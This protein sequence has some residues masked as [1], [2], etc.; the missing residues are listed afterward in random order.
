MTIILCPLFRFKWCLAA[1]NER[2]RRMAQKKDGTD[3]ADSTQEG[4]AS[5]QIHLMKFEE[6]LDY[7][8]LMTKQPAAIA[9]ALT[10]NGTE[11]GPG[12]VG[13]AGFGSTVKIVLIW[14]TQSAHFSRRRL[15]GALMI[16]RSEHSPVRTLVAPSETLNTSEYIPSYSGWARFI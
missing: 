14:D 12:W 5:L 2:L 3:D 13:W 6:S 8:T 15:Q 4:D 9:I 7:H 1:K 11:L 16:T 10:T